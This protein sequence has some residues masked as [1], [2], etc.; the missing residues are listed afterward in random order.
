MTPN[1]LDNVLL[2]TEINELELYASG[3]VRDLYRVDNEH[4]LFVATDRISA[5]DYILPTGI[6][7]KGK[8]LTQLSV[9]WFDFLREVVPNHFL[10][11]NVAEYPAEAAKAG[12][13]VS[14]ALAGVPEITLEATLEQ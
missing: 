3:K 13:P 6:P 1:L 8:V 12:C 11:A 7:D 10:T 5:F 9:F 4:L 14:R 2:Q